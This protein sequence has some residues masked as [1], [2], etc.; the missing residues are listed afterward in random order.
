[1]AR[2]DFDH[3][4]TPLTDET[5]DSLL[6]LLRNHESFTQEEFLDELRRQRRAEKVTS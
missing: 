3:P 4:S 2:E 5:E 1:M 6:A